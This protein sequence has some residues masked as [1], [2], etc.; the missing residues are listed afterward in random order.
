VGELWTIRRIAAYFNVSR[1]TI[2]RWM[3][4][5]DFPKP[6]YTLVRSPRWVSKDVEQWLEQTKKK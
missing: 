1:R 6:A 3:Q 2:Y 4:Q 5:E